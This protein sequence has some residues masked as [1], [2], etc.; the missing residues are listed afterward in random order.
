MS[1]SL[2]DNY[3]RQLQI[4]AEL[5]EE[6][7]AARARF[8]TARNIYGQQISRAEQLGYMGDYVAQLQQRYRAFSEL[9]DQ[10]LITL[11]RGELRIDGQTERLRG[12][13]ADASR[14]D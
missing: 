12:L 13:M 7:Q 11:V 10:A 1:V 9:M 8:E 4:L 6:S 3:Q 14:S 2:L 5:R